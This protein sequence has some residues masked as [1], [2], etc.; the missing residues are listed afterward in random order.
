[1]VDKIKIVENENV[2]FS[3]PFNIPEGEVRIDIPWSVLEPGKNQLKGANFNFFCAQRFLDISNGNY[4]IT[5]VTPDAPIWEIGDMY[6][7]FW[8]ADMKNRPWLKSYQPSQTLYSWVMNNAWFVNYKAHQEGSI[9][10]RYTLQPHLQYSAAEAKKL[11]LEETTPLVIIPIDKDA[12][13]IVPAFTLIGS[14]DVIVTSFKPSK[15]KQAWMIRLFNSSDE[16]SAVK[17]EWGAKKPTAISLSSPLEEKGEKTG[18]TQN[19]LPW[20]ILTLRA[21][22]K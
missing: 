20:E 8:M 3:F 9:K 21:E 12:Q 11:G 4:G 14:E 15:D 13:S 1:M 6:G 5:L 19:L 2:R 18:S 22:I 17:I 16:V 10:F 7:Q